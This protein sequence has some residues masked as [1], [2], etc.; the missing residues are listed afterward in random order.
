M[1]K[2]EYEGV[3]RGYA[4]NFLEKHIW[5]L[6]P[7]YTLEDANQESFLKYL[8]CVNWYNEKCDTHRKNVATFMAYY[9]TALSTLIVDLE[10]KAKLSRRL[11]PTNGQIA[12][13]VLYMQTSS[14]FDT[15]QDAPSEIKDVL[16]MI[17]NSPKEVFQALGLHEKS[18]RWSS[19]KFSALI[20]RAKEKG[21]MGK[22]KKY[23]FEYDCP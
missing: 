11:R 22:I 9:K 17:V 5:K 3:V 1:Y 13:D 19:L 23:L 2:P 21:F 14:N 8:E 12:K 16:N 7:Y 18:A 6:D 15:I 20:G 10:R 4:V